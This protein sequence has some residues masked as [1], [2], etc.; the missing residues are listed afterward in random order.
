MR[1][2]WAT[3]G[4]DDVVAAQLADELHISRLFAMCLV[5]R[6]LNHAERAARFIEPRLKHLSDPFLIPGMEAAVERLWRAREA[7]ERVVI[8][9]DYDVDGV[10]ATAVLV[11]TFQALGCPVET[12]LPDRFEEGYGLSQTAVENCFQ[13]HGRNLIVAV[14]CGSTSAASIEWLQKHGCD[15]IVLDHHQVAS[16][17][18]KPAALVNPQLAAQGQPDFRELCSAGLAFKLA[19]ALMKRGRAAGLPAAFEFDLRELLDLVALATIADVVPLNG[20]NRIFVSAGL[21]RLNQT[22]RPG[23]LALMEIAQI[24]STIKGYEVA[25]QLAPRLNAAGRL[26]NAELALQLLLSTEINEART[27]ARRLDQQ[28]RER[29]RIGKQILDDA[30]ARLRDVESSDFVIV[31]GEPGWHIGVVGI[32]ASRVLQEFYRPTIIFGGD[33]EKWRGSGRSIEGFDLAGGLRECRDLLLSHGG[34]AMA[35]GLSIEPTKLDAFRQ[36]INDIARQSLKPEQLQPGL[37]LDGETTLEELTLKSLNELAKLQQTGIGNPPVQ[38][39]CRNLSFHRPPKRMGPEDQHAKFWVTDG[40][41]IRES[42]W[43]NAGQ[44]K[45]PEGCFDLAFAP[46]A[47][48]YNGTSSVQL[49]I[50]DW[51]RAGANA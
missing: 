35:A 20:E 12:Y 39:F 31:A 33:G 13:R 21:A 49:R 5:N 43:W 22:T 9:G 48:H 10:S 25:F 42:V 30:L 29:Q 3:A 32:V 38:F 34:H 44:E 45:L 1:F 15:V 6:G 2:R 28:N 14:D 26:E 17:A 23:L 36:R 24:E 19:H 8:F 11:Q 40:Q 18:P 16:P 7:K 41:T 47:N 4:P 37:R 46:E 50:L 51:R 27:I